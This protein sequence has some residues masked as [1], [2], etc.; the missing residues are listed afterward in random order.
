MNQIIRVLIPSWRFFDGTVDA[1]VLTHRISDDGTTFGEWQNTIPKPPRR[2]WG[3]L[4][5]NSN[6]NQLFASHA[7]LEYLKNDL[8]DGLNAEVSIELVKNLV[9]FEAKPKRFFQFRLV[10]QTVDY[11]SEVFEK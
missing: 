6:E 11:T 9:E 3:K 8:V 5:L 7:L 10:C 2:A 1:A 4:F